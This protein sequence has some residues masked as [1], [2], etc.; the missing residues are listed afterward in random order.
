MSSKNFIIK[1]GL[2]VGSTEVVDSSGDLTAAAFGTAANEAIDD[3][4]NSLL[5]AGSGISLSYNDSAGTLTITRDAETGDIEGVTAGNGLSGGGTS[6]TVS[7]AVDLNELSAATVNVANDS[8]ALIDA[9]DSNGSKKESIADF[10]SAIAGSGLSASSGQLSIS[11][12]GDISSVTAGTGLS[13]GGSSG[14]VTLAVDLSELT[15]MT[16]AVNSSQDELIILDNGADRRKL[17]SEIPLS[18][19]NNDSGFAAGDITTVTAGD[20]LTGGGSSGDVSLAVSVDDSSIETSSDVMRVK[21]GGITNAMLAGSIA[22]GK[23]AGSIGNSLLSNSAITIDGTSVSLGGSITTNNTVDMGD[24]FVIEDGD[25][26]EVTITENK[27]VK[28]VEGGGIDINW[29]DTSTGSDGD[30]Y[31]LTFT[32]ASGGVTNDMLAGSIANSKLANNQITVNSNTAALG[33]TITLD[34]DDIGEG[35]SN[36]YHTTARARAAISAG[37]GVGISSGEISI[38]QAVATS[39]NVQFANLTLSGNLTVN[40][41]TVTNS[42]SNTTI[43]DA[44]IELGSGNSGSN[45]NDLGLILERGSTGDNGFIGFDESADQF[46]VATTTA[47]GGSSGDLSLTDA[48]FRANQITTSYANNSGGVVRNIYQN[49]SAPGASDGAVGDLWILYS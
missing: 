37:T 12:T 27:E 30:P 11:E 15:D 6:G 10:V 14:D 43:E 18:A 45:S 33:G 9:D 20:G 36:L 44:L 23:L 21:A 26:T 48:N 2:T 28:F 25:G 46:V 22:A 7:L 5:T 17:I 49:T 3:Q 1:N 13:G 42:A 39:S 31:D 32:I 47:T 29:T 35:S 40:G 24:G 41:S 38:G 4:V 16:Q 34:S 19:F 8:I